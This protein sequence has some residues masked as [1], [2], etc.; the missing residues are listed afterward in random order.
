MA[1][2]FQA[3]ILI[4]LFYSSLGALVLPDVS[5]QMIGGLGSSLGFENL[6]A[7]AMGPNTASAGATEDVGLASAN[8]EEDSSVVGAAQPGTGVAAVVPLNFGAG[9]TPGIA[10][11]FNFGQN[12]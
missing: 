8:S 1:R 6:V 9:P 7:S 10:S 2:F 11:I 4:S 5:R 3:F 12:L